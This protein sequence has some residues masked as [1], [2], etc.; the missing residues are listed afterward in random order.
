MII[1]QIKIQ[2]LAILFIA[3]FGIKSYSSDDTLSDTCSASQVEV[4]EYVTE[5]ASNV[6]NVESPEVL[7]NLR[8]VIFRSLKFR[9]Y[10]KRTRRHE[11]Q[12]RWRRTASQILQDG[13]VYKTKACTDIVIVFL[14]LCRARGLEARFVKVYS[15][16]LRVHSIAEVKLPGGWFVFDV[17]SRK[18]VP[19]AGE[20]TS[21]SGYGQWHLWKKGRDAWD[22]GL[23]GYGSM[24]KIILKR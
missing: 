18:A 10:T 16:A 1:N 9:P 20:I 21:E 4:T 22:I 3:L 24:K 2:L 7:L 11:K 17:A 14:A 13:Y 5:M 6:G 15:D 23:T 19:K 8:K 12:I